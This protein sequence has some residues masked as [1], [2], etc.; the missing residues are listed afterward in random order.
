MAQNRQRGPRR[1]P[2]GA[3]LGQRMSR[4][5]RRIAAMILDVLAGCRTT[6]EAATA[7]EISMMRYYVLET[8][9]LQGLVAACEPR[10]KGRVRS[11]AAE[12]QSLRR[13]RDRLLREV[14]RQQALVR[15]AQKT[16]G[17]APPARL[18]LKSAG[19]KR[20]RRPVARALTV[21]AQLQAPDNSFQAPAPMPPPSA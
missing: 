3:D 6:G 18:P 8:R 9:A 4:E 16:V 1:P 20:R 13:E 2:G 12:L 21:A 7:L 11:P 17:L 14:S 15:A 10:P 19:K 5:S